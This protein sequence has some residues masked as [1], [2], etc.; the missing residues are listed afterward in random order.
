[1]LE[2]LTSWIQK[3]RNPRRSNYA[4]MEWVTHETLQLQ[5][6]AYEQSGI[7]VWEG[8]AGSVPVTKGGEKLA[9]LDLE[10]PDCPRLKVASLQ[11]VVVE[12]VQIDPKKAERH[13]Q[14]RG[15]GEQDSQLDSA[16]M[17]NSSQSGDDGERSPEDSVTDVSS[18][19]SGRNQHT[20]AAN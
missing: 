6:Q 18:I 14:R 16:R 20:G 1:M 15:E 2:P 10:D 11:E 8:C 17:G 4:R 12:T 13:G 7:G 3:R 19:L 5:R 9:V